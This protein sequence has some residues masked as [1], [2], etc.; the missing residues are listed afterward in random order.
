MGPW[1]TIAATT[2]RLPAIFAPRRSERRATGAG[3]RGSRR[4]RWLRRIEVSDAQYHSLARHRTLG[5]HRGA[6]TNA[7]LFFAAVLGGRRISALFGNGPKP[8]PPLT[9]LAR[10][11]AAPR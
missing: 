2:V 1:L 11:L 4:Q 8:N 3:R 5:D 6:S 10:R 7:H 9:R